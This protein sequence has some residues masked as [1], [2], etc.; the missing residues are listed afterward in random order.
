MKIG[1]A[2]VSSYGQSLEVQK[3]KLKEEGCDETFEKKISALSQK[4]TELESALRTVREGDVL[5]V[6]RLDRV[7][8]LM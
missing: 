6:P 5:V 3:Q 2:R 8:C 7:A 4:R 1:Y